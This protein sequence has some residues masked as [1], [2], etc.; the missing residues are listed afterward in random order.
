M[1]ENRRLS[2][3]RWWNNQKKWFLFI[4][5]I[6]IVF[7][8]LSKSLIF[9]DIYY[10]IS[11]PFWPGD[12]QREILIDSN[13]KEFNIKID[14]LEYDN[15]RLRKLL[16]LQRTSEGDSISASVISRNTGSWW[17]KVILNK[18]KRSGIEVGDAVVG[19]GGLLGIVEDISTFTASTRLLTST[20]SK[21]GA[22]V[23][24]SNIH[25]I[26][27]GVGNDGPKL[28]FYEKDID[29]KAG[30]YVLSSPASTLLPPNLPIGIIESVDK[31]S[32][33]VTTATVQL[34]ADPQAI[35]WVQILK[36][37]I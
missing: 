31:T 10:F 16:S 14:Q 5:F 22:W 36:L 32:K 30:D 17:K 24:R 4:V 37:K 28:M 19:P 18:G 15:L 25:G 29:I 2:S 23:Q 9:R 12:F 7:L 26:L 34:T 27:S 13:K 21:V 1:I 33:P 11:K 3:S 8:R 35:D 20:E 6:F